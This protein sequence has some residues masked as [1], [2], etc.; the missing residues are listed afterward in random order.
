[1]HEFNDVQRV[2]NEMDNA[3]ILMQALRHINGV[4]E[5]HFSRRTPVT[6]EQALTIVYRAYLPGVDGDDEE[7]VF[8]DH[9]Q[10]SDWARNATGAVKR[11]GLLDG[12]FHGNHLRPHQPITRGEVC[13]LIYNIM[14]EAPAEY[15]VTIGTMTGGTVTASETRARAGE[16]ITLT[17]TPAAGM[18]L[19]PGSLK[20]NDTTVTGGTFPTFTFTMPGA[21]VTV[22]AEFESI[23]H[24]VT[25]ASGI[26]GGTVTADKTRADAGETVTVTV[27]PATGM[28]L[29][30]G[31]LRYNDTAIT[32]TAPYTFTMPDASVVI[33]AEFEP[34]NALESI[35]ITTPPTDVTYT[36]GDNLDLAGLVVTATFADGA[37]RNVTDYVTTSPADNAALTTAGTM[38]VTVTYTNLGITRTA[39]FEVTVTAA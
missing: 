25:I 3:I 8:I 6:R 38:T 34:V 4:S 31:S 36:V 39:T 9:A 22:T 2:T 18:R 12:V 28:R 29:V 15:D 37:T 17:V 21:N 5:S 33:T 16:T 24:A 23:G 13:H 10:I 14:R 26:T 1:M 19:V 35:A 30:P 20:Y 32:G 27:A 7:E 11:K